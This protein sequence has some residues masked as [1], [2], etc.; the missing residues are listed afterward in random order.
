MSSVLTVGLTYRD[1]VLT[2]LPRLPQEGEEL[3]GQRVLES[4]GGIAT[5]ARVCASLGMTT[6]IATAFGDDDAS[7]RCRDDLTR[8][9]V[10]CSPSPVHPGWA[11]PT[12]LALCTADDRAMATVE[13]APP[14]PVGHLLAAA[15]VAADAVIVDLRDP[16]APWL[17]A[18]RARGA[19]VYAS[20]GFDVTGAWDE[21][22]VRGLEGTDVWM[23]NELE[24]TAFTGES[25]PLAAA[26]RLAERTPT[27]VVTRGAR[28]MLAVDTRTGEEATVPAMPIRPG[29]LTGAGDTTLAAFAHADQL[30]GLPLATKLELTTCL[31]GT[32]LERPEGAARVPAPGDYRR[33]VADARPHLAGLLP[34]A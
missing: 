20:R 23:L 26:R 22:A 15:P 14:E 18:A 25:D 31:V 19:R 8:A 17:H 30:P 2:G 4:W 12:T 21:D 1:V 28:G 32:V 11:L 27:V 10:D 3:H 29:N 5:M 24:A 9:G 34:R 6:A 33:R 7:R 13:A 16:S